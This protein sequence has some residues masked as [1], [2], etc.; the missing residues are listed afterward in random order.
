MIRGNLYLDGARPYEMEAD[1]VVSD[2][3]SALV[4]SSD[5]D[6]VTV[7]VTLPDDLALHALA[8]PTTADLGRVR[9]PDLEFDATDGS[10][11]QLGTDLLG[12][13]ADGAVVPGPV[14]SFTGGRNRVVVW[15]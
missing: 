6:K 9:F 12:A 10:G 2:A 11:I 13:L 15:G 7:E 3:A 4:V 5:G 8:V 1:P 14:G